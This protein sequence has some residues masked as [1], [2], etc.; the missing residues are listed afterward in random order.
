MSWDVMIFNLGTTPP[1][2]EQLEDCDVQPLGPAMEVRQAISARLE[3]VDWSDP[4]WGR[5][6]GAGFSIEF[7]AG[8]DD[9]VTNIMLR[10]KGGG[11]PVSAIKA[12][13][14]PAGWTAVDV[15][16]GDYLHLQEP[17]RAAWEEH[18]ADG[19]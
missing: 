8:R 1:P 6:D 11:D 4:D 5:Y 16:S 10:V 14:L 19:E 12:F 15:S 18:R 7:N 2:L 17:P 13:A 9:P 3:G